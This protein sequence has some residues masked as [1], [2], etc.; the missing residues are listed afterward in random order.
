[1]FVFYKLFNFYLLHKVESF[2]VT[3]GRCGLVKS[4]YRWET[5]IEK[6]R[7]IER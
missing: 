5:T 3:S 6:N 1:M 2:F 7:K 4:C